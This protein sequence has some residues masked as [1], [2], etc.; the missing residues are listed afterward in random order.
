ML[1][2]SMMRF[3]PTT[4][5]VC[6][7]TGSPVKGFE[8]KLESPHSFH[9]SLNAYNTSMRFLCWSELCV[10]R[11]GVVGDVRSIACWWKCALCVDDGVWKGV[12]MAIGLVWCLETVYVL[13]CVVY[14]VVELVSMGRY[15]V[16]CVL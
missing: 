3:V 6:G 2:C 11:C 8:K 13:R 12:C 15:V 5:A 10:C 4:P 16:V 7:G 1:I 9:R 14:V